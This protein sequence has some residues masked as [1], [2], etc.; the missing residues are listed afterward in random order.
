MPDA[1]G[2]RVAGASSEVTVHSESGTVDAGD[3]PSP[4]EKGMHG[5]HRN[6]HGGKTETLD[7]DEGDTA[8]LAEGRTA[9]PQEDPDKL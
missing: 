9:P 6:C 3:D 4:E 2:S 7:E 1:T 8:A 5:R